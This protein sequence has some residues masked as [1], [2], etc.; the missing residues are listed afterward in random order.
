MENQN[1]HNPVAIGHRIKQRRKEL[2]M[3]QEE[4]LERLRCSGDGSGGMSK[5]TFGKIEH[6]ELGDFKI[7]Q[8]L[9]LCEVLSCDIGY[10]LCE[11]DSKTLTTEQMTAHTGLSEE[12]IETLHDL[13]ALQQNQDQ[14][15]D[16]KKKAAIQHVIP[17]I[18]KLLEDRAAVQRVGA[19]LNEIAFATEYEKAFGGTGVPDKVAF[20]SRNG[21]MYDLSRTIEQQADSLLGNPYATTEAGNRN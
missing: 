20:R 2:G 18:N 21:G 1:V 10:L 4:L 9:A 3:S 13:N 19:N 5:V 8:A 12:S 11:Y 6:G 7:S 14:E 17:F 16:K 15:V